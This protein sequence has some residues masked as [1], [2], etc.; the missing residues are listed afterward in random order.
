MENPFEGQ[1][2]LVTGGS[3]GIGAAVALQLAQAGAK[4]VITGRHEGRCAPQPRATRGSTTS[5]PT[6][7]APDDVARSVDEVRKR[8]GRLDA[9]INNAGMLEIVSARRRVAGARAPHLGDERARADRDDARGA[10]DAAQVEGG[11]RQPGDG[12]RRSAVRQHVGLLREQG[13][14][15]GPD[16]LLG[17]GAGPRRHPR[18]RRQPGPDRDVDVLGR[19]AG[20]RRAPR[21]S[22]WRAPCWDRCR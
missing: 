20:D 6:W 3:T 17:A 19:E 18:Q 22:S 7:P 21:S 13:G 9:L 5:S 4:V 10:A 1:V 2:A 15:P 8:L 16:A 11:D 14:R 12:D